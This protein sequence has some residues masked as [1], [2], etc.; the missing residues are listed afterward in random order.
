MTALALVALTL[1]LCVAWRRIDGRLSGIEGRMMRYRNPYA[2][3]LGAEVEVRKYEASDWERC[4]VTAVSWH[5][6]VCVR[7]QHDAKGFWVDS[8]R[9]PTHVREIGE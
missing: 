7:R 8:E 9:A 1:A 2:H 4:V 5:G 3:L 6:A